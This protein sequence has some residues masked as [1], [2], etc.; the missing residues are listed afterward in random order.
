MSSRSPFDAVTLDAFGTLVELVD[1][2]EPLRD[3]LAARGVE[4]D[5]EAVGRA[6]RAEVAYYLPRSWE[7]RDEESLARLRR[8][9]ARVFLTDLGAPLDPE[10]FAP[11][12]AASLRFRLLPGVADTLGLLE[13]SGL[14]LACVT[15]WDISFADYVS[16]LGIAGRF[17][18]IVTSAEAGAP[19]PE[20]AVFELA[21]AR[22]HVPAARAVHVGDTEA[23]R[24][25]ARRAG[26]AFE[27]TPL[28][29]LPAR[30]GLR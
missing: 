11:S 21:L 14:A 22:L 20:P 9:C 4:R 26:L 13:T 16:P 10:E 30:L 18:A 5:A 7:G 17:R 28:A 12:F 8:E 25:G 6:F 24:E 2:V 15:N 23:D 3:A 19:K 27:P 1:P 29:T